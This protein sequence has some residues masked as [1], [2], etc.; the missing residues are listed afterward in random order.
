MLGLLGLIEK[1]LGL[2]FEYF[3]LLTMFLWRTYFTFK[4]ALSFWYHYA[5]PFWEHYALAEWVSNLKCS[6]GGSQTR[7]FILLCVWPRE[8]FL[9]SQRHIISDP[10]LKSF[11]LAVSVSQKFLRRFW[12]LWNLLSSEC[13]LFSCW[14][15]IFR[16]TL[17]FHFGTAT[18]F[19][20]L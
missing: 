8:H 16:R 10:P 18:A 4:Y 3:W 6:I 2:T 20:S 14:Y 12:C 5:L 9:K 1:D 7:G 11:Q 15:C 13:L 17:R 19:P